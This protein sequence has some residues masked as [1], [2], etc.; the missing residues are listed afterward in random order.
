MLGGV[1]RR[2]TSPEFIGRRAELAELA[3]ALAETEAGSASHVLVSGEAGVGKSRFVAE[4]ARIAHDRGWLVMTGGCLDLGEGGAPFGP[5][6]ELLRSWA[7]D[8]GRPEATALA[9]PNAPDLGRLAPELRSREEGMTQERWVQARVHDALRDLFVRLADRTPVLVVLEDMHWADADTLG[10]TG[11]LLRRLRSER[12]A[13]M[14]T[15]R[16]DELHRRH[17]LRAW[18]AEVTRSIRPIRLELAP[19]GIAEVEQLVRGVSDDAPAADLVEVVHRRSDGNPFFAEELL[20]SGHVDGDLSA[21]LRDLLEARIG[22]TSDAARRVLGIVAVVGRAVDDGMLLTLAADTVP[23]P[24][25]ATRELVDA[26]LL[27]AAASTDDDGYAFRHALVQEAAYDDL[28]PGER[29]DLHRHVAMVL[30]SRETRQGARP[31]SEI[32]HHWRGARDLEHAL[33]ASVHAG[34]AAAEAYAFSQ[35]ATEYEHALAMWAQVP[36]PEGIAGIDR[37]EL[38]RRCAR[39]LH[40]VSEHRRAIALL[41][42]AVAL[43]RAGTDPLRTGVLLAQLARVVYVSGD[44]ATGVALS[45]EAVSVM[46]VDPP[47]AERARA[48]A[49]LGQVH[50]LLGNHRQ[51]IEL[52]RE[53]VAIARATGDR[54]AEGHAL[55]TMGCAFGNVGISQPGI[56]ALEQALIIAREVRNA[57]DIGRAYVNL[58]DALFLAGEPRAALARGL[59]GAAEADEIGIGPVYGYFIR[60]NSVFHAFDLGEWGL[61]QR[62]LTEATTRHLEDVGTERYRLGYSLALEVALGWPQAAADWERAWALVESDPAATHG[63][64]PPQLG[65]IELRL[66][67]GRPGDA[68]A[69]AEDGLRRLGVTGASPLILRVAR[70]GARAA[71]DLGAAG[72]HE[73][74]RAGIATIERMRGSAVDARHGMERPGP[75]IVRRSEMELAT[76]DAERG[77]LDGSDTAAVWDS[78]REGWEAIEAPYETAYCAIRAGIAHAVA[79]DASAGAASLAAAYRV[80][81]RLGAGPMQA[82]VTRVAREHGLRVGGDRA[83]RGSSHDPSAPERPYGLTAR[84]LEVLTLVTAGHSNRRIA[85]RLFI[86]EN[87]AG[88]HVSNILGKLDVRSRTEAARIGFDLGLTTEATA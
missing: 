87:T 37:I 6:A 45:E 31:W 48:V 3:R 54:E 52:C 26:G 58:T 75:G 18:L 23:E 34:D 46:P 63:T 43:S 65:G 11:T 5:F 13:M 1:S 21:S 76:L 27:V 7:R 20:A 14:A 25:T 28:L 29:R 32:A 78:L 49:G 33:P 22:A 85:E 41:R 61:S 2:I 80:T 60:M 66:W 47:T 40:L 70:L 12:V 88:V 69:I 4:A 83:A 10:A 51:A 8:I 38:L 68:V 50:M 36:H 74:R 62:L 84:E 42:E 39:A 24:R 35:A 57:D 77:R 53:A 17:P 72:T 73:A 81:D 71:A 86:S 55:N 30:E 56:D 19:F 59:V 9:G 15:Y 64:M 44:S 16:S 67:Q 79:G 82:W